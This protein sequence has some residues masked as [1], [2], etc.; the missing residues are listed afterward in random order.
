MAR[1]RALV[2]YDQSLAGRG[3]TWRV[4]RLDNQKIE[5]ISNLTLNTNSTI[6]LQRNFLSRVITYLVRR[7]NNLRGEAAR[8]RDFNNREASDEKF[9]EEHRCGVR[10]GCA[11]GSW[12]IRRGQGQSQKGNRDLIVGCDG[13]RRGA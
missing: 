3:K 8:K 7:K 13:Q 4:V 6:D 11:G 12:R 1:P 9:C 2:R 5:F 10:D